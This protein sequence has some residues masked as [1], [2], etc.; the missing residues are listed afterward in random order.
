MQDDIIHGSCVAHGGKAVLILGASG[1]GKSGLALELMALGATLV[2]D[3]RVMLYRQAETLIARAPEALR[4]RIEARFVGILNA[5]TE[6]EAPLELIVDLD[7][8]ERDRLPPFRSKEILGISLP[9]LH[10]VD[11]GCFPAAIL[12]YLRAG[13]S[14]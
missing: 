5:R 3:D 13:R 11:T 6:D 12:Q 7:Q 9:V 4:G 10:N 14:D 2:A 1:A 8:K